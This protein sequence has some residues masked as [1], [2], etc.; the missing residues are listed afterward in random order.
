MPKVR[1][2]ALASHR[3]RLRVRGIVRLEV[4]VGKDDAALVRGVVA[5]LTDPQR[6]AEARVLLRRH[7]SASSVGSLKALLAAAPLDGVD[8]ARERDLPRDIESWPS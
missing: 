7:F 3:H 1:K 5:A 2:T 6:E 4:R 8:L